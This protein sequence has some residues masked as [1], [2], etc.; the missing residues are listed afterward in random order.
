MRLIEAVYD[1]LDESGRF[2]LSV[3]NLFL[4]STESTSNILTEHGGVKLSVVKMNL[5]S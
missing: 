5:Y 3:A 4:L 2:R 1:V